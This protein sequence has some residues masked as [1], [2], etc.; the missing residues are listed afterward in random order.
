MLKVTGLVTYLDAEKIIHGYKDA[1]AESRRE[2]AWYFSLS[3]VEELKEWL[4]TIKHT[5]MV[6]RAASQ[7]DRGPDASNDTSDEYPRSSLSD[8]FRAPWSS[9]QQ[10]TPHHI[11]HA[12]N[13]PSSVPPMISPPSSVSDKRLSGS[14]SS[15]RSRPLSSLSTSSAGARN[16]SINSPVLVHSSREPS[17]SVVSL[18]SDE[19]PHELPPLREVDSSL[20]LVSLDLVE[21]LP[22]TGPPRPRRP[23]SSSA[24]KQYNRGGRVLMEDLDLRSEGPPTSVLS[25]SP[26]DCSSITSSGKFSSSSGHRRSSFP[27][28]LLP[29]P[30]SPLPPLPPSAEAAIL[31]ASSNH[32]GRARLLSLPLAP[33]TTTTTHVS[34]RPGTRPPRSSYVAATSTPSI[35]QTFQVPG[36]LVAFP[37]PPPRPSFDRPP[38]TEDKRPKTAPTPHAPSARRPGLV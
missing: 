5:I 23:L 6:L 29:P 30:S 16:F 36:P 27:A 22:G 19:L 3:G 11:P 18:H 7:P 2:E 21:A 8:G 20:D 15:G 24:Q 38:A 37:A 4:N 12:P 33:T 32:G 28:P 17:K 14:G 13:R 1:E 10:S 25:Q 26:S 31:G 35:G 9:E 34:F